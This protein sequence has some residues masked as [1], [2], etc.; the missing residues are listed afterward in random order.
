MSSPERILSGRKARLPGDP[1]TGTTR[2]RGH[3][4]PVVDPEAQA[5]VEA[6]ERAEAARVAEV[7]RLADERGYES[8]R[9]RAEGE[10]ASAIAAAGALARALE[11]AVPRDVEM[12]ARTVA[13]LAILV[14]RRILGA[15]LRHDPSVLIAAIE[16]GLRQAVG[17]SS[18]QVELHN[19]A[20]APVQEAWLARH[21]QRHR[22]LAWSFVGDPTLPFGGCRLRTEYGLVEAGLEDQLSEVAAAL[23]AAIP[24]YL[25]AALGA[26]E[27]D[28]S[29]VQPAADLATLASSPADT[30]RSVAAGAAPRTS[31]GPDAVAADGTLA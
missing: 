25:T 22:G 2:H 23:D 18:V 1:W 29:A 6:R 13:E 31:A 4:L 28:V 9:A 15:E 10:L 17:A 14:S 5:M 8:G 21:G 11:T 27:A 24:G 20:V 7:V 30:V 16:A 12:V 19:D 26:T 3:V